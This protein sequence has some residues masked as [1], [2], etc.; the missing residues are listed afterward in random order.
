MDFFSKPT[1]YVR[2]LLKKKAAKTKKKVLARTDG[3]KS[4][5]KENNNT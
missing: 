3:M 2:V 4:D 1:S 5:E